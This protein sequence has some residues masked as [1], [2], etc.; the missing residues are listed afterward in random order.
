M[1]PSLV[2][3]QYIQYD[4]DGEAADR[5]GRPLSSTTSMHSRHD[6]SIHSSESARYQSYT[7]H[8]AANPQ[9]FVREVRHRVA[10]ENQLFQNEMDKKA[11][12]MIRLCQKKYYIELRE[13]R[14]RDAFRAM[15]KHQHDLAVAAYYERHFG[16]SANSQ[17]LESEVGCGPLLASA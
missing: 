12:S 14:A 5:N 8:S 17:R 7:N 11:K 13:K 4:D 6:L 15:Q 3:Q 2:A 9:D 1:K 10:S 16:I